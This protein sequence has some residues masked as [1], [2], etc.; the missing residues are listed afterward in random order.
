MYRYFSFI[1]PSEHIAWQNCPRNCQG[2]VVELNP[3]GDGY[4]LTYWM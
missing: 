1:Y 3:D 4:K 2:A